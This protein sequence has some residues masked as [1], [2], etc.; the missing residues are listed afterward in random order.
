MKCSIRPSWMAAVIHAA[1]AAAA[2]DDES[3]APIF[4]FS[5]LGIHSD[6][7]RRLFEW[8]RS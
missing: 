7:V 8:W 3:T 1:V 2:D 4:R 6:Q 5:C